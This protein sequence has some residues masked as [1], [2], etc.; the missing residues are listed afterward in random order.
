MTF[1]NKKFLML[2]AVLAAVL[3][4]M[5]ACG[6]TENEGP[7]PGDY[8]G[9][10]DI[11][12][13]E[14]PE[15]GEIEIS[16]A[17]L[18]TLEATTEEI[19]KIGDD[20]EVEE[21]YPIKGVLLEDV[22]AHLG[23][24]AENLDTLRFTA[25]DGYSVEVPNH[26]LS[27][28]KLILAFEIDG[29]PLHQGTRPVRMFVPGEESMYWVKNTVKISITRGESGSS[30]EPGGD[31]VGPLRRIVFFETLQST[32]EVVD[33]SEE[34][35]AKAVNASEL[36]EGVQASN[37]VHMLASDGFEK[38]EELDTFKENII[39]VQGENA[40]AFRGLDLPRGMHVKN[41]VAL[42]TGDTGFVFVRKGL[43]YFEVSTVGSDSGISLKQLVDQ[44]GLEVAEIYVLES[45]DGYTVELSYEDLAA[46][47]VYIREG[48]E[49]A[50]AFDGLPKNTSVKYLLSISVAE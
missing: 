26:I 6:P 1:A 31:Q 19:V 49:L 17:E 3:M 27:S 44:L 18:M 16:V 33:Y 13:I 30:Q 20:G 37:L 7:G 21:Q 40:P 15:K 50:S 23:I 9:E 29:E 35:G 14:C 41:L 22:L 46:G 24:S 11:I 39:V 25:G 28:R 34:A 47:I 38:N 32:L 45:D 10:E 4:V 8:T 36:L 42:A 5:T 12:T 48:G 43:D 2:I